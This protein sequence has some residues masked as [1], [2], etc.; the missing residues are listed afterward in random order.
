[1]TQQARSFEV[2][3][4]VAHDG[5]RR[6]FPSRSYAIFELRV[7]GRGHWCEGGHSVGTYSRREDAER[8]GRIWVETGIQPCDQT[9]ERLARFAET[10]SVCGWCA[11]C[12]PEAA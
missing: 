9:P 3:D 8:V 6:G 1:M 7:F 11:Q 4:A 10:G 5:A 12:A 2:T